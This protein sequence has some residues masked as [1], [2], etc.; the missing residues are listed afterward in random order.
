M[1]K[2]GKFDKILQN[3][4]KSSKTEKNFSPHPGEDFFLIFQVFFNIL[5][6]SI[7]FSEF[8]NVLEPV[9]VEF[10]HNYFKISTFTP[11]T[12]L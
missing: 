4:K 9:F 8:F 12:P 1:K 11:E 2:F 5:K 6:N 7:E 10:F 3:L